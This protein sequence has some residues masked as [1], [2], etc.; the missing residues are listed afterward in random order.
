MN[1]FFGIVLAVIAMVATSSAMAGGLYVTGHASNSDI[2]VEGTK[3]DLTTGGGAGL[4]LG[5]TDW[6]AAEVTYDYLGSGDI[7]VGEDTVSYKA[8]SVVAWAVANANITKIGG[9]PLDV[10]G[11]VGYG[12][13]KVESNVGDVSDD[14]LAYGVGL[15]LGLTKNLATYVDYRILDTEPEGVDADFR[16]V[17]V[18]IKYSF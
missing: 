5:L 11:R 15:S 10:T 12:H 14:H 1:K 13:T 8:N 6:L 4:G 17:N 7:A 16:T 9:M 3:L 2:D 18:G